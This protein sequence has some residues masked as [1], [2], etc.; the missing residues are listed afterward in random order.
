MQIVKK[1]LSN[2][3]YHTVKHE[4]N[5]LYL[6]HTESTTAMS[7]WRWWNSTPEVVGTAYIIDR[8]GVIYECFDPAVWAYHLGITH[9]GHWHNKHSIAIELV[10]AG[11]LYFESGQYRF[12]PLWPN[13]QRYTVIPE[14]EVHKLSKPWRGFEYYHN[15]NEDQLES[16]KWLIGRLILDFPTIKFDNPVKEIFD[17]NRKVIEER[18]P[19]MW[20]HATV[21]TDKTDVFPQPTL[22]KALEEVQKEILMVNKATQI[23]EVKIV[24]KKKK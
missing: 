7:A 1:H 21:R 9:H 16:L 3:Q 22:I 18:I 12:Y 11:K 4:K 24:G 2:G 13:K 15:Y 10:S 17:Y 5:S 8:D 14:N 19:G 23:P 20:S 6:H